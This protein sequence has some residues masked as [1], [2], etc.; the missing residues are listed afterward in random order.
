MKCVH[1]FMSKDSQRLL[2]YVLGLNRREPKKRNKRYLKKVGGKKSRNKEPGAFTSIWIG[3]E[4]VSR[5]EI[6]SRKRNKSDE[7]PTAF[8]AWPT[9]MPPW[10][11]RSVV[12]W[13]AR[14][15][16]CVLNEGTASSHSKSRRA[17]WAQSESQRRSRRIIR[18]RSQIFFFFFF[19][20]FFFF[21][22]TLAPGGLLG[23]RRHWRR[24][25]RQRTDPDRSQWQMM[26]QIW[27]APTIPVTPSMVFVAFHR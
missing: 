20:W 1:I 27:N 23:C 7:M 25:R 21:V 16:H 11:T 10:I 14:M 17:A 9:C 22:F 2:K 18:T 12:A 26:W 3:S 15:A 6:L 8:W 19:L 5:G 24:S 4:N 13:R